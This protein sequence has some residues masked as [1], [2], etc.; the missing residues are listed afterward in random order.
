[1]INDAFNEPLTFNSS[2][3]IADSP[4]AEYRKFDVPLNIGI[5]FQ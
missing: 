1:M 2:Q 3:M 5:F 4:S